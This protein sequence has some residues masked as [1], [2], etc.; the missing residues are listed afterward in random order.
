[1]PSAQKVAAYAQLYDLELVEVI[2]DA[3]ESAKF[4]DR[5]GLHRALAMLKNG[6]A[7]AL[8]AGCGGQPS[9]Q[10]LQSRAGRTTGRRL[11]SLTQRKT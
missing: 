2:V 5:A 6:E 11:F 7:E 8:L 1:M 3:G 4:L 10:R 9:T